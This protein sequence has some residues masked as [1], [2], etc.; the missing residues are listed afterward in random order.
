MVVLERCAHA[1]TL[2][3]ACVTAFTALVLDMYGSNFLVWCFITGSWNVQLAMNIAWQWLAWVVVFVMMGFLCW[4]IGKQFRTQEKYGEDAVRA[5]IDQ[6]SNSQE[7]SGPRKSWVHMT[8]RKN[9]EGRNSKRMSGSR[10]SWAPNAPMR[11]K[12]AKEQTMRLITSQA[13]LYSLSYLLTESSNIAVSIAYYTSDPVGMVPIWVLQYALITIPL[14]GF[15]NAIIYFRPR[16][17]KWREERKKKLLRE[18]ATTTTTSNHFTRTSISSGPFA[19]SGRAASSVCFREDSESERMDRDNFE[20]QK[21]GIAS[22][23]LGVIEDVDE[24]KYPSY[25]DEAA[26][27]SQLVDELDEADLH[28]AISSECPP[29][30]EPSESENQ[31]IVDEELGDG[32][33]NVARV[34]RLERAHHRHHQIDEEKLAAAT[35]AMNG[36]SLV[37][38]A[39]FDSTSHHASTKH[40]RLDAASIAS[41]CDVLQK[42][43]SDTTETES[44]DSEKRLETQGTASGH[45]NAADK[46]PLEAANVTSEAG[47]CEVARAAMEEPERSEAAEAEEVTHYQHTLKNLTENSQPAIPMVDTRDSA[48][49]EGSFWPLVPIWS[50]EHDARCE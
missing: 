7:G 35:D 27:H 18:R 24:T 41:G 45:T 48:E 1:F 38:W 2:I 8:F 32:S 42:S 12:S 25:D 11:R 14:Q 34:D 30:S 31:G 15:W 26:M 44:S 4:K 33:L 6:S 13:A 28:A 46:A 36:D 40:E 17:L 49:S 3:F 43:S 22:T 39:S 9:L 37:G 47:M 5:Q 10:M 19:Q 50:I 23:T 20:R 29:M 21:S 16:F